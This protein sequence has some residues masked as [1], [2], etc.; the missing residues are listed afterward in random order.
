MGLLGEEEKQELISG[1]CG[2]FKDAAHMYRLLR[3]FTQGVTLKTLPPSQLFV[4]IVRDLLSNK[5]MDELSGEELLDRFNTPSFARHFNEKWVRRT[6]RS[7]V[8]G[9]L[10]AS[11]TASCVERHLQN[12]HYFIK[13]EK[14]NDLKRGTDGT[15]W[16][17][18]GGRS[19]KFRLTIN[20]SHQDIDNTFF[21]VYNGFPERGI[22]HGIYILKGEDRLFTPR[23][24]GLNMRSFQ[25]KFIDTHVECIGSE[26]HLP[27]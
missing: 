2:G 9:N 11:L 21:V 26:I 20:Q 4:E 14:A 17:I 24:K 7:R 23:R 8:E 1:I 5:D 12:G 18:K 16:E 13:G 10:M 25:E 15:R 19:K 6:S 3:D 27:D 22:I